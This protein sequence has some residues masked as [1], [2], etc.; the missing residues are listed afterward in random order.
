MSSSDEDGMDIDTAAPIPRVKRFTHK[1]YER[2]LKSVHTPSALSSAALFDDAASLDDTDSTFRG[3]LERWKQLC[4]SPA[5]VE[6]A[7]R[8]ERGGMCGS[9][10]LLLHYKDEVVRVWCEMVGGSDVEGVRPLLDLLQNLLFDLRTALEEHYVPLLTAT[11]SLLPRSLPPDTL[12]TL[13]S[14]L[15]TLYKHLLVPSSTTLLAPTWTGLKASLAKVHPETR[16]A[17]GEGWGGALR[18]LKSEGRTRAV[19]MLVEEL[20]GIEEFA[21]YTLVGACSST[22]QALHSATASILAPAVKLHVERGGEESARVLRRVTTALAHHVRGSEG[23]SDVG[24]VLVKAYVQVEGENEER[25]ESLMAAA[26]GVRGGSRFTPKHVQSVAQ[27]LLARPLLPRHVHLSTSL[28]LS[29]PAQ[30]DTALSRRIITHAFDSSDALGLRLAGTLSTARVHSYALLFTQHLQKAIPRALGDGDGE[31]RG[32]A[33]KLLVKQNEIPSGMVGVVE[34]WA[35]A[36]LAELAQNFTFD[37]EEMQDENGKDGEMDELSSIIA[38]APRLPSVPSALVPLVTNALNVKEPRRS[39]KAAWVTS[40]GLKAIAESRVAWK[41]DTKGKGKVDADS[42]EIGRWTRTVLDDWSWSESV[43]SS[44]S[45]L[46]SSS[47]ATPPLEFTTTYNTLAPYLLSHSRRQR[48]AILDILNHAS[49]KTDKQKRVLDA[50]RAAEDVELDVAGARERV[51]RIGRIPTVLGGAIAIGAESEADLVVRWLV[52]QLKVGL[53]PAWT[54][55]CKALAEVAGNGYGEKVWGVVWGEMRKTT[56][57]L[58]GPS[59]LF[60][61]GEDVEMSDD[62]EDGEEEEMPTWTPQYVDGDEEEGV[63]DDVDES[64]RTWRDPSAHKVRVAVKTWDGR[65]SSARERASLLRSKDRLD[66]R[67]YQLQLI[68]AFTHSSSL[69]EKHNRQLVPFFFDRRPLH[70]SKQQLQAWLGLLSKFGNPRACVRSEELKNLYMTLLSHPDRPTQTAALAC[71]LTFKSPALLVKKDELSALLDDTRRRDV[72]SSSL[73]LSEL[74]DEARKEIGEVFVRVLFGVMRDKRGAGGRGRRTGVLSALGRC[75]EDELDLLI[76]LMLVPLLQ[77]GEGVEG[78]DLDGVD[79][80]EGWVMRGDVPVRVQTGFLHTAQDVLRALGTR[81]VGRWG[82]LIRAVVAIGERAQSVVERAGVSVV[83]DVEKDDDAEEDEDGEAEEEDIEDVSASD[84]RTSRALR[85]HALKL[86]TSFLRSETDSFAFT[87]YIPHILHLIRP[88]IALLPIE[89]LHSPSALLNLIVALAQREETARSVAAEDGLLGSV[90]R[91]LEAPSAKPPALR[92]ALSVAENVIALEDPSLITPHVPSLL[93]GLGALLARTQAAPASDREAAPLLARE[94]SLLVLLAPYASDGEAAAKLVGVLAPLL[95]RPARMVGEKAKGD[96]LKVLASLIPVSSGE[97]WEGVEKE[98]VFDAISRA[99][100]GVRTRGARGALMDAFKAFAGREDG[101]EE[102]MEVVVGV[103]EVLNVYDVR[104]VDVPDYD[105]RLEGFTRLNEELWKNLTARQWI[106]ILHQLLLDIQDVEELAIRASAALGMRRFIDAVASQN[107]TGYD[108]D[109]AEVWKREFQRRLLPALK[110]GLR[111][112][113]EAVR[114][115]V[116]GVLAHAI[117]KLSEVVPGLEDMKALL[118]DGDTEASVFTNLFH[119]QTHR[120]A[121]ALLRLSTAASILSPRSAAEIWAPLASGFISPDV[122]HTLANQAISTLG[123]LAGV[124][125]WGPYYGLV[126]RWLRASGEK[127]GAQRLSVRALVSV[128][129]GFHF[130]MKEEVVEEKGEGLE[131]EVEEE[132]GEEKEKVVLTVDARV[133]DAVMNKLL[134]TLLNHLERREEADDGARLPVAVGIAQVARRLPPQQ[135]TAQATRLLT[136]LAQV[137]RSKSSDTR[138]LARDTLLRVVVA[139]GPTHL[140]TALSELRAALSRG[141]HIHICAFVMHALLVHVTSGVHAETFG[142]LDAAAPDAAHVAADVVFGAPGQDV[143]SE[144]F[145]TK[146]REVRSSAAKGLDTFALLARHVSP[147]RVAVLLAP[148][149][150]VMRETAALK[151]MAAVEDALRRIASGL[152]QNSRI[153]PGEMLSLCHTLISQNAKFLQEAPVREG[154]K[155]GKGKGKGRKGVKEEGVDALVQT[156][157][158]LEKDTDHYATNSFRF[159]AFGLD[160]FNTAFRR[161]RFDFGDNRTIGRLE[162]MVSVIGNT[163]YASHAAVLAQGL[164]AAASISRCPLKNVDKALPVFVDQMVAIIRSTGSTDSEL[165]QAALKTLAGLLRDKPSAPISEPDLLFLIQLIGPDLE[166]PERQSA[167]FAMLRAIVGRRFVVPEIYD[168]M[169]RVAE[170]AVTSQAASAR[171]QCRSVLLAFLLDY[172]QGAGRLKRTMA[173][174]AKNTTYA[175]ES[176]RASVLEL[177]GAL[178]QKFAGSLLEEYA[179]MVFVALVMVLANDEA[180]KCKEMAGEVVK[181]LLKRLGKE[182]AGGLLA[183]V[184][185]WARSTQAALVRVACQVYGLVL[186]ALGPD[187]APHLDVLLADLNAVLTRAAETLADEDEDDDAMEVEPE[188]TAPYHALTVL[189][190]TLRAFPDSVPRTAWSAVSSLLL[191]PHAWVRAASARTLGMLFA[192]VPPAAPKPDFPAEGLELRVLAGALCTQLKSEHLDDALSLQIVKNL[193]WVGKC[194]AAVPEPVVSGEGAVDSDEEDDDEAADDEGEP[195]EEDRPD[196]P[197]AWLFSKLSYQAR[198]AHIARRS[199]ASNEEN[200]YL[201]PSAIFKW[202]AA[203]ATHLDSARLERYLMHILAPVYR[204]TEESV[205]RDPHLDELKTT[206]IELQELVQDKVGT[207]AFANIYARIRQHVLGVQRERRTARATQVAAN[208]Q[209]A[210]KRRTHRADTKRESKKRK[211]ASFA[212]RKGRLKRAKQ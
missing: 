99:L 151:T 84:I 116:L 60:A 94:I 180:P 201:Q 37:V 106:P 10:G 156:K 91:I 163:L 31:T 168:M 194:F 102:G 195:G 134:P 203:M 27:R 202:F 71:I 7:S 212:D 3:A 192:A 70:M 136:L 52:A 130:A 178:V 149:R 155:G 39:E 92:A 49:D 45:S 93:S 5:F 29:S 113:A 100:Q 8:V 108:N 131:D 141:P 104:R 36:R 85:T 68:S 175:H 190:K 17:L 119:V 123:A 97:V 111:S 11:L 51:V 46:L 200:W 128:L 34:D 83:E 96:V 164:K 184:H 197:L 117:E 6:F 75:S 183:H 74:E 105:R 208:P 109:E 73:V 42:E 101:E 129:E 199:R 177:L 161:G 179:D 188:W 107:Q 115:E 81:V 173:F 124:M 43:L 166:E 69:S 15:S 26:L 174:L 142:D 154:K 103:L 64:E 186:E 76:K 25:A 125:A 12:T 32:L 150:G 48:S 198:A 88:R 140:P 57:A 182:K 22:S 126:Q 138:D 132:D 189:E 90:F 58:E 127:G 50:V 209:A 181:G 167:V 63:V 191:F 145:K 110:H 144:G 19:E 41:K 61:S 33:L 47:A 2:Q 53:R 205:I 14:T 4:L 16:R 147:N 139:L 54:P 121:R 152:N 66:E 86:L 72:L 80:E 120:R 206:A 160:L 18:R 153:G 87:P 171:E 193:F 165:V 65:T 146:M 148:L 122:D 23:Y 38:L 207:T 196:N 67:T 137:F 169:D 20:K 118:A 1:S 13:L 40:A 187:A 56:R 62:E 135:R 59:S 30:S 77:E 172:P 24:D 159:V 157:R 28:L 143:Q 204:I 55:A 210:A 95:R 98:K 170:V 185:A 35:V 162:P 44:L 158:V 114:G 176:G 211:N 78:L 9:M 79:R 112:R 21:A 133:E 89:N 82:L